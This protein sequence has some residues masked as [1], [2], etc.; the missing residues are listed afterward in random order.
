MAHAVVSFSYD[1][2]EHKELAAWLDS[3]PAR[4]RSEAIRN[5]LTA[6]ATGQKGVTL[7][8][9]YQAIRALDRKIGKGVVVA[10]DSESDE[11]P[12][13]VL[14]IDPDVLLNLDNMGTV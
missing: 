13:D 10:G 5:I 4:G 3:L 7:G 11:N 6:H 14:H 2:E 8:D 9:V 12:G 1:T